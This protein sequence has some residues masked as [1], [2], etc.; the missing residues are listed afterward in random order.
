MKIPSF[1]KCKE[2][3]SDKDLSTDRC[4]FP[5][6]QKKKTNNYCKIF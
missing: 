5:F 4:S 2:D 1:N 3:E 6:P